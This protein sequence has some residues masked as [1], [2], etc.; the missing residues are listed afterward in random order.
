MSAVVAERNMSNSV[1]VR[2]AS[3]YGVD[4]DKMLS[5]LKAT[6][7]KGDVSNEQLM[8][9]LVVADQY[10]LNPWTREIFAFPAQGGIVPV[11]GVDGWGRIINTHPQFDGMEF[12]DGEL[13]AKS[14]PAWIKC[15]IYRKDRSHPISCKEYFDEVVRDT[16]PWKSHP[17]RMLRHKAVIQCAR[18]AFGFA[19]IYD[20]DE[21]ERIIES[22]PITHSPRPDMSGVDV[23]L[24]DRWVGT[25]TDIL[26]QDKDEY[27]IA[28][29]LREVNDEL[30]KL[31]A[32]AIAVFDELA[33]R[34]IVTKAHYRKWLTVKRPQE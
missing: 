6:C 29:D 1:L 32:L 17:R 25:I 4:P 27:A 3:R 5:T 23:T 2:M 30:M 10:G 14:V 34:K 15:T 18:L 11:V 13:N 31:D 24:R 19:G 16:A 7:F 28:D 22:T 33:M 20:Q 12:E 26:A 8:A 21:G 9:L